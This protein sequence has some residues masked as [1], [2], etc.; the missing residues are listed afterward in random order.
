M[1]HNDSQ[2]RRRLLYG[3]G[4][5]GVGA[6]AGCLGDG[7]SA[8]GNG[9]E[10]DGNGGNGDG[11]GDGDTPA[12]D[13]ELKLDGR[14]LTDTFPLKLVDVDSG[15][16]VGEVQWHETYSHWHFEPFEVPLEEWVNVRVEFFDTDLNR[17]PIGGD[18]TYQFTVRRTEDTPASLLELSTSGDI[19]SIQ[20]T[21]EGT[22]KLLFVLLEGETEHWRSPSLEVVVE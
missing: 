22:G 6:V 21:S 19:A 15:D 1:V 4:T 5:T 9:D 13:P 2:T 14:A 3:L 7:D 16:I 20:G 10:T 12:V 8:S 18:E 11:N 17:L